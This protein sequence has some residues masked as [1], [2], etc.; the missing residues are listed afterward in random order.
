MGKYSVDYLH[1]ATLWKNTKI[2]ALFSQLFKVASNSPD[3]L[4]KH[5]YHENEAPIVDE[6]ICNTNS[7]TA[8]QLDT[9]EEQIYFNFIITTQ[10][11]INVILKQRPAKLTRP[12]PLAVV[13]HQWTSLA[14]FVFKLFGCWMFVSK[15]FFWESSTNLE[16]TGLL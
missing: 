7:G 3:I 13:G 8:N 15:L 5:S 4:W 16:K 12:D 6:L 10:H 11:Q 14:G 1:S 9:S 2:A